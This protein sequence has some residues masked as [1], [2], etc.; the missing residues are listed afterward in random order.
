M[1]RQQKRQGAAGREWTPLNGALML[2][3][4]LATLA[5]ALA[6]AAQ[7]PRTFGA[8]DRYYAAVPCSATARVSCLS[9]ETYQL[10]DTNFSH[11]D[12]WV[13]ISTGPAGARTIT[14]HGPPDSAISRLSA[15]DSLQVTSWEGHP[16][17]IAES[18]HSAPADPVPA[19]AFFEYLEAATPLLALGLPLA[20]AG[21]RILLRGGDRLGV[22]G[23]S[24]TLAVTVVAAAELAIGFG[25]QLQS[26]HLVLGGYGGAL[27]A[28]ALL[29]L[30]ALLRRRRSA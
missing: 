1:G 4:G 8:A 12:N 24:V 28:G 5:L 23:T 13:R 20:W 3:L 16:V 25:Q 26:M 9:T 6:L 10:E 7:L 11:N 2:A 21:T 15:G 22:R 19:G 30:L 17:S 29:W 14:L 18:G 27:A